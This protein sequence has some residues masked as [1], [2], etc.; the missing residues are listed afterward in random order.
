MVIERFRV[1]FADFAPN[2]LPGN[3]PSTLEQTTPQLRGLPPPTT[4]R[5]IVNPATFSHSL[6]VQNRG[7]SVNN[8]VIEEN[9]APH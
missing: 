1:R 9:H 3:S 4:K 2:L 6:L 7:T 5:L 8:L